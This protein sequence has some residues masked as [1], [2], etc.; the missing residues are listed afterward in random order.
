MNDEL[1]L[2]TVRVFDDAGARIPLPRRDRWIPQKRASNSEKFGAMLALAGV[3]A[4]LL[5]AAVMYADWARTG[6]GDP[7]KTPPPTPTQIW[8]LTQLPEASQW[9][10]VWS[11][12]NG[13]AVLRPRWLPRSEDEYQVN[14]SI[15][16]SSQ[17]L[18]EYSVSYIERRSPPGTTVWS[19]EFLA[20]PLEAPAR[21]LVH[22]GDV[23]KTERVTVRGH[24]AE[25]MG[26]GSPVWQLVWSEGGYRYAI[27]G[28]AISREDLLRVAD[29]LAPV[30]DDTGKT[31]P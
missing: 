27:Q 8:D 4:L 25:L 14:F 31:S 29:S 7:P 21:R 15:D 19:I 22:L 13:V 28:F 1:D 24:A 17:R 11:L 12:S 6:V 20:N 2:W 23:P 5:G 3:V 26:T 18:M 16:A 9:G 10:R 30:I